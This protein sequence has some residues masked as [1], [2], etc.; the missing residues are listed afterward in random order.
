MKSWLFGLRV[1]LFSSRPTGAQ[2]AKSHGIDRRRH[3]RVLFPPGNFKTLPSLMRGDVDL[4]VVNLS[5]G[6]ACVEDLDD[7]ILP[8]LGDIVELQI[9]WMNQSLPVKVRVAGASKH[10]QRHLEFMYLPETLLKSFAVLVNM[11][12]IGQGLTQA[13]PDETGAIKLGVSELWT[14]LAGENLRIVNSS[15]IYATLTTEKEE[16]IFPKAGAPY[17]RGRQ[18]DLLATTEEL[19]GLLVM[20]SNIT[21]PSVAIRELRIYLGR[22]TEALRP[23][24]STP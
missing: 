17:R 22:Q 10:I 14:T 18:G 20:V 23:T 4:P 8:Q 19:A 24:G 16:W 1:P 3:R 6:G 15:E 2:I 11:G 5:V 13:M 9:R 21:S 7:V 12:A